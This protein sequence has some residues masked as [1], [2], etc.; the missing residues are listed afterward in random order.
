MIGRP[1]AAVT[2]LDAA[3][4]IAQSWL[5]TDKASVSSTTASAKV[6]STTRIGDPGK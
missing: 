6:A 1:P 3:E 4:A 2:I 5:K